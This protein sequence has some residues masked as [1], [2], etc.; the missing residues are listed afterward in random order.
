MAEFVLTCRVQPLPGEPCPAGEDAWVSGT[1]AIYANVQNVILDPPPLGDVAV[2]MSVAT[3]L[4]VAQ[5]F[6]LLVGRIIEGV[7]RAGGI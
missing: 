2:V 1:Q 5:N 4:T 3:M 6:P 7:R